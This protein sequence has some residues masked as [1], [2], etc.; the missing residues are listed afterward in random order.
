MKGKP[1][2]R[3]NIAEPFQKIQQKLPK[4][5][6]LSEFSK[7][8]KKS[9]YKF[10]YDYILLVFNFHFSTLTLNIVNVCKIYIKLNYSIGKINTLLHKYILLRSFS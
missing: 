6:K 3:W 7:R 9:S 8:F 1:D 4:L 5:S 10:I 2:K